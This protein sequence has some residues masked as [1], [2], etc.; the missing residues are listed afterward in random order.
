[1]GRSQWNQYDQSL[2]SQGGAIFEQSA[3]SLTLSPEA[4]AAPGAPSN[5]LTPNELVNVILKARVELLW[6]G[7]IGSY[8]KSAGEGANPGFTK[9]GRVASGQP[10]GRINTD[11]IDNSAGVEASDHE[12]DLKILLGRMVR[13]G[14]MTGEARD[15]FLA[16]IAEEVPHVILRNNY[17][18]GQ[19]LSMKEDRAEES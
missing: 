8:I 16:E 15:V 5:T 12:V 13:A 18:Q 10:A 11:F 3:K 7:G 1:M 17:C 2:L 19:A 9:L 4:Q 6:F 14:E